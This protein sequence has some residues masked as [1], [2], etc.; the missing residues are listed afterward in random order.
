VLHTENLSLKGR[1]GEVRGREEKGGEGEGR[2]EFKQPG[3]RGVQPGAE[4]ERKA[5]QSGVTFS[6]VCPEG[7]IDYSGF[8]LPSQDHQ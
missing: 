2:K 4:G 7:S 1:G 6:T 3:I 8:F 5:G